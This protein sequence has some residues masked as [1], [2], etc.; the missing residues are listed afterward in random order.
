MKKSHSHRYLKA[1]EKVFFSNA[2][3]HE[4]VFK[5]A[6]GSYV[7]DADNQSY[8]DFANDGGAILHG[9]AHPYIA[10]A[11]RKQVKKG[12]LSTQTTKKEIELANRLVK[13]IKGID[14]VQFFS[15]YL[16]A[17]MSAIRLSRA[18]TRKKKIIVF[19]ECHHS[20]YD[21]CMALAE[22][23]VLTFSN[24]QSSPSVEGV[25]EESVS[26]TI[27]LPINNLEKLERAFE[28]YGKELAAVLVEPLVTTNGLIH[29]TDDFFTRLIK[30]TRDND[31][32]LIRDEFRTSFR[33]S[34]AQDEFAFSDQK[35]LV[36]MGKTLSA[37]LPFAV[38]GY[39]KDFDAGLGEYAN[40]SNLITAVTA[41]AQLDLL[42]D[43]SYYKRMSVLSEFLQERFVKAMSSI[44]LK[45]FSVRL[46]HQGS[47][48]WLYIR[49]FANN[50][51]ENNS[52]E[53][54]EQQQEKNKHDSRSVPLNNQDIFPQAEKIYNFIFEQLLAKNI[55]L[56]SHFLQPFYLNDSI[57]EEE[58]EFF[59]KNLTKT[60]K[61]IP[62]SIVS[63]RS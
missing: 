27:V 13:R 43:T 36:L 59:V 56:P 1:A 33:L 52:Q 41:L 24:A 5:S 60:I 49:P 32:I 58:I 50:S 38:I 4:L 57:S 6:R 12:I 26:H 14:Q 19:E 11:L 3:P 54:E 28:I 16:E 63:D 34:F 2:H 55:L 15:S 30:L 9:H 17:V 51:N 10:K 45:N 21:A 7:K 31:T 61:K 40:N 35:Q 18:T 25:L 42:Q 53:E 37:G 48:F 8:L 46:L 23:S 22:D 44:E 39:K 20:H 29:L 47:I 62:N